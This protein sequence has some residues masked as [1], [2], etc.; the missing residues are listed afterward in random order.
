MRWEADVAVAAL[1]L[2]V[3]FAWVEK[4]LSP[5]HSVYRAAFRFDPYRAVMREGDALR[6]GTFD[7]GD[8]EGQG[9]ILF[10][11]YEERRFRKP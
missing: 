11:D 2:D 6:M 8:S 10:G 4:L 7:G 1:Q 9:T 3:S 5:E